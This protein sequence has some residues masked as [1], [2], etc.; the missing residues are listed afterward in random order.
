MLAAVIT[1]WFEHRFLRFADFGWQSVFFWRWCM[2]QGFEGRILG[3]L[4]QMTSL[5]GFFLSGRMFLVQMG[6]QW[7]T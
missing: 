6:T 4:S 2:Q 1:W 7:V 5:F 3:D